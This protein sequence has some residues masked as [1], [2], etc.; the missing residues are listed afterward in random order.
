MKLK[1]S[2]IISGFASAIAVGLSCL[3]SFSAM[4]QTVSIPVP[5]PAPTQSSE[6]G[7]LEKTIRLNTQQQK[8]LSTIS[9]F[10]FD[11]LESVISSGFDPGKLKRPDAVRTENLR[12]QFSTFWRLDNQQKAGLRTIL[13]TARDQMKRQMEQK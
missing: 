13:Q 7:E 8:A 4:A 12:Q 6:I 9:E 11:Q 3:S 5:A 10:A 1:P 2:V